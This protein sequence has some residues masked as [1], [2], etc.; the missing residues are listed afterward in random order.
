MVRLLQ[1]YI[2]KAPAMVTEEHKLVMYPVFTYTS[3]K[4]LA[5][6]ANNVYTF[7]SNTSYYQFV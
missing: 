5:G 7:W 2:K 1:A 3:S 6:K 4:S